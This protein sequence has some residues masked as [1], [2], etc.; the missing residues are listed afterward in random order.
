M[1]TV[2]DTVLPE[3][4]HAPLGAHVQLEKVLPVRGVAVTVIALPYE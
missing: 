3:G 4:E 1:G 2:T